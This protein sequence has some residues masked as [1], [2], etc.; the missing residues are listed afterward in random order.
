M[1]HESSPG[2]RLE[3]LHHHHFLSRQVGEWT[4]P[5]YTTVWIHSERTRG[6]TF[7]SSED[8]CMHWIAS[9]ILRWNKQSA[10]YC[11]VPE[12]QTAMSDPKSKDQTWHGPDMN[13]FEVL[14]P[15]WACAVCSWTLACN[16]AANLALGHHGAMPI[17]LIPL[18]HAHASML[19]LIFIGTSAWMEF[20]HIL[21]I[22]STCN[23]IK[24]HYACMPLYAC[25]LH[26]AVPLRNESCCLAWSGKALKSTGCLKHWSCFSSEHAWWRETAMQILTLKEHCFLVSAKRQ[27]QTWCKMMQVWNEALTDLTWSYYMFVN[28]VR[29]L[30]KVLI[31]DHDPCGPT[32]QG[33]QVRSRLIFEF[34]AGLYQRLLVSQKVWWRFSLK[35]IY[36]RS[37][38]SSELRGAITQHTVWS[39]WTQRVLTWI[40][41]QFKPQ[42]PN[43]KR[44]GHKPKTKMFLQR[45]LSVAKCPWRSPSPMAQIQNGAIPKRSCWIFQSRTMQKWWIE[46]YRYTV[47]HI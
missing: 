14:D 8:C 15:S 17:L 30:P 38:F 31:N 2:P 10:W 24:D 33:S 36:Y 7:L 25:M 22:S 18:G 5:R 6:D 23:T 20:W 4:V 29:R 19:S 37:T 1:I 43:Q 46:W 26:L 40:T 9:S 12:P 35:S 27:L 11:W 47:I 45:E 34:V 32:L 3:L 41:G 13:P 39:V 16:V 42:F 21:T 44:F 28:S